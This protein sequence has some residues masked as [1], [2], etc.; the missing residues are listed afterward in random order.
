MY[1]ELP[2]GI[3]SSGDYLDFFMLCED[4]FSWEECNYEELFA[5]YLTQ[6]KKIIFQIQAMLKHAKNIHSKHG[7]VFNQQD[8]LTASYEKLS[9]KELKH[10]NE[11]EVLELAKFCNLLLQNWE[12]VHGNAEYSD[13]YHGIRSPWVH[14][15]VYSTIRRVPTL[16]PSWQT[17]YVL[18]SNL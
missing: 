10:S 11:E 4:Y 13:R 15:S 5:T 12:D 16:W 2:S 17:L 9:G 14:D 7:T 3:L 18:Y 6:R 8:E 1:G